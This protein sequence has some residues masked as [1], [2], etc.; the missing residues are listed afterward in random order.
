MHRY[1]S[2][3][4]NLGDAARAV[5]LLLFCLGLGCTLKAQ[6]GP[7]KARTNILLIT[8]DDMHWDS[9]GAFGCSLEDSTPHIDGLAAQGMRFERAHVT[10]AI[11]QPTRAVWMTGRYPHRSGA[12]GFTR[13]KPGVP[14]LPEALRKAGY[15]N[16]LLA[17]QHHVIPSR[18]AAFD[19][20]V[21]GD[22]LQ[23]GRSPE[24]YGKAATDFFAMARSRGKPFFLMANTQDPHRPFAGSQQETRSNANRKKKNRPLF[25]PPP[26]PVDPASVPVPAF[27]PDLPPIRRELAEYFTSVKRADAC[28]GAVL[29]ALEQSGLAGS[30]M[31]VFLSDHGMP[32]PF[33]KTNCWENSTRTPLI[34]RWPGVVAEKAVDDR[35]FVAGIDLCPTL[36][37][38]VGLPPLPGTDGHSYLSI[39]KGGTQKGREQIFTHINTIASRKAYPMRAV[40]NAEFGYIWNGWSDGKTEFRNESRNGRTFAAMRKASGKSPAIAARVQHFRFRTVEELYDHAGDPGSRTNLVGETDHAGTLARLRE[41]LR[42]HM[43]ATADPQLEAFERF[44]ADV[45]GNQKQP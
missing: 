26:D 37:D 29:A 14:A 43:K 7:P 3:P 30:T 1:L 21:H 41:T 23:I 17:K 18:A 25:P 15:V 27:L 39:L 31:V 8:V 9:V 35:H 16:G 5:L 12:L 38:A 34:V 19:V 42:E 40:H 44:L 20:I 10:I 6:E 13:I 28:V 36:L 22:D 2:N 24:L 4:V 11:C 45:T 32:L 33:A